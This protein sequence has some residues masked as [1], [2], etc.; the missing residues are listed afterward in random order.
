MKKILW[1]V[2]SPTPRFFKRLK[3]TGIALAGVSAAILTAPVALPAI[4]VTIAGYT[5]V[6]GAV[7]GAVSQVAVKY[8]E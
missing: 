7:I 8:D 1:R 6:A 3:A 2:Q 5:A 4:V